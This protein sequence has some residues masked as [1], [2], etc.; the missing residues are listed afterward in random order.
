MFLE[1]KSSSILNSVLLFACSYLFCHLM[2]D[3]FCF[4]KGEF[5]AVLLNGT[6]NR[7]PCQA[8]KDHSSVRKL[9]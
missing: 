8:L 2:R 1:M 4:Q 9:F 6:Y 5:D 3:T 7:Q